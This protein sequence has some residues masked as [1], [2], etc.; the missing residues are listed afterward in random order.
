[1]ERGPV[2]RELALHTCSH[3]GTWTHHSWRQVP[4][5]SDEENEIQG[6]K[7]FL[8]HLKSLFVCA[9]KQT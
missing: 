8:A 6:D 9:K 7:M 1:M 2:A 3:M 5:W 4:Y